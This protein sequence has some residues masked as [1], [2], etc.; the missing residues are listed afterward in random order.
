M[1]KIMILLIA[2]AVFMPTALFAEKPTDEDVQN[3]TG[4]V[5]AAF[6]VVILTSMFGE[7]PEGAD[8]EF[9]MN[10]GESNI[11]FQDFDTLSY[12][13]ML[14]EMSDESSSETEL[15]EVNFETM[16][17]TIRIDENGDVICEIYF[18]GGNIDSLLFK[19]VGKDLEFMTVNGEDF[20][21]IDLNNL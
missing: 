14:A 9:D 21:D 10:T 17:G 11:I 4:A 18:K 7:T 2:A 6:G 5:L 3:T 20:S 1:K 15:P 19:T 13:Q 8:A 16:S 12:F